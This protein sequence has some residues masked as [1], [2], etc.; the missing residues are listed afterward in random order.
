[1]SSYYLNKIEI[2]D[3]LCRAHLGHAEFA[4]QI[5][6]SK[7]HWSCLLNGH[8]PVTFRVRR[9]LRQ[10]PVTRELPEGQLWTIQKG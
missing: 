9:L 5:G 10:H 1:M 7:G 2:R 6:L 4:E 8:R 3:A